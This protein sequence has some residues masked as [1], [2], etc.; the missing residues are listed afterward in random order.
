MA[1]PNNSES[2]TEAGEF[3]WFVSSIRK[4]L[5]NDD[6]LDEALRHVSVDISNP[7][8]PMNLSQITTLIE[9]LSQR[10]GDP[11]FGLHLSQHLGIEAVGKRGYL[12]LNAPNLEI[13]IRDLCEFSDIFQRD[14]VNI[15]L[16]ID[17]DFAFLGYELLNKQSSGRRQE[18]ESGLS[19]FWHLMSLYSGNSCKL[20]MVE[21][22]HEAP[23]EG[24]IPYRK[25][26]DAPVLFGEHFNRLHFRTSQLAIK[27]INSDRELYL[28]L[29][30][31]IKDQILNASKIRTFAQKVQSE[32]TLDALAKGLRAKEIAALLGISETTLYRRLAME[33]YTFKQLHDE[34]AK[35]YACYLIEQKTLQIGTITSKLGFADAACLTRAFYR[36]FNMSPQ[37]YR[38]SLE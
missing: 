15:T 10:L 4:I 13:A 7:N 28:I 24:T 9:R 37:E 8:P 27:S 30:E 36:W 22:E 23:T 1:I 29:K 17:G 25:V 2:F 31:H 12:F 19:F 3:H 16:G 11:Y 35:S 26:F 32:L 21:F 18:I 20:S 38:R 33:G 5:N 34:K 14:D 6:V